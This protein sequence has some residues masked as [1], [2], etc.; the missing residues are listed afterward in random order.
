MEE[1][2]LDP[3]HVWTGVRTARVVWVHTKRLRSPRRWCGGGRHYSGRRSRRG[4]RHYGGRRGRRR[5][6]CNG[7]R[8]SRRGSRGTRGR[9][10]NGVGR[11]LSRP[12]A[13]GRQREHEA[14]HRGYSEDRNQQLVALFNRRSGTTRISH[15]GIR[16]NRRIGFIADG[17]RVARRLRPGRG[18][19]LPGGESTV[20]AAY[21]AGGVCTVNVMP[22]ASVTDGRLASPPAT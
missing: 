9:L 21:D 3:S 10:R 13:A 4:R 18:A 19:V 12:R 14:K 1:T 5:R 11:R 16:R 20:R 6:R 17:L 22:P 15:T 8:R 7:G 2:P